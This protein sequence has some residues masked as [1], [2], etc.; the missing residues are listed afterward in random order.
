[1]FAQAN[2][3]EAELWRLAS[4]LPALLD[5]VERLRG[6]MTEAALIDDC[7]HCNDPKPEGAPCWWCGRTA[8]KV[9]P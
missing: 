6:R 7:H 3:T 1:V 2:L 5:E 4:A 9:Q 8:P